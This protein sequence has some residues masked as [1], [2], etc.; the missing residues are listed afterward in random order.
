MVRPCRHTAQ[1]AAQV[2]HETSR[3]GAKCELVLTGTERLVL[4]RSTLIRRANRVCCWCGGRVVFG[5]APNLLIADDDRAFRETLRSVFEPRGFHTIPASDGDEA[6]EIIQRQPV[7]LLLTDMHMPRMSGLE[8]IRHV[9][10][11][12]WAMPC[13]LLSAAIDEG[14]V[15]EARQITAISVLAKPVRFADVTRTV[16]HALRTAYAWFDEEFNEG[17][18]A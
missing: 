13:I 2:R 6:L 17:K 15:R 9:K 14:I 10:R 12:K 4:L 16:Y 18:G 5:T 11:L 7:H 3:S 8:T 1:Q